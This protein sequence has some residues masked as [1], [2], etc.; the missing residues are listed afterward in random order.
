MNNF[1]EDFS[2]DRNHEGP[3]A[4][5]TDAQL[6]DLGKEIHESLDEQTEGLLHKFDSHVTSS[7]ISWEHISQ[8]TLQVFDMNIRSWSVLFQK[9]VAQ[10]KQEHVQLDGAFGK[11]IAGLIT[12]RQVI[13]QQ[14]GEPLN[15]FVVDEF[16]N[17]LL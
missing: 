8:S 2:S 12:L 6:Q 7:L 9:L 16:L 11:Y 10:A 5:E 17:T 15:A 4:I 1:S 13:A 3:P 14:A